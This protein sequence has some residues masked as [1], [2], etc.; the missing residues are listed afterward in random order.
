MT[1]SSK[2]YDV[3]IIGARVA[4]AATAMLLAQA[5]ARVLLVDRDREGADTMS[6]HAL[7]RSAVMQLQGWG[8][9]DEIRAAGTPPVRRT[10]FH[11]GAE[12]VEVDLRPAHGTDAL[13]APRRTLLDGVLA[14]AARASGARLCYETSA[15]EA[16]RGSGGEVAGLRLIG[17]DCETTEVRAG[18]V[19]GADGRRSWLARQVGAAC[20]RRAPG[21]SAIIYGYLE[22]VPDQGYRWLYAPG[23]AAG[24]IPTNGEQSVVFLALAPEAFGA[25]IADRSPQGFLTA[26]RRNVPVVQASLR[27]AVP[28]SRPVVFSGQTGF[29]RDAAGPG[30]ALVGDAG[31][32]KDPLTANGIADALRDAAILS[33][34]I[35]AGRP[36]DYVSLRNALSEDFFAITNE[37]ASFRWTLDELKERH[38]A[39]NRA[40]KPSQD[41]V[42]ARLQQASRAA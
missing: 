20:Q 11:Y 33:D 28:A 5:G 31:Y 3:I 13:Y 8:L 19:I 21:S 27:N 42:A 30:W 12:T 18:L 16:I 39:L 14:H 32:F 40:M 23:A 17:P 37:I 38:L 22:G 34:A 9:L 35:I 1:P 26:L 10:G 15:V 25:A 2:T 4:G 24:I 29:M 41:W 6:T 36:R 7:M